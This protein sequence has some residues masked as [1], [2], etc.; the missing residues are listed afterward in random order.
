MLVTVVKKFI[1]SKGGT[2]DSIVCFVI[3][4]HY[5]KSIINAYITLFD[6]S[7]S[8]LSTDAMDFF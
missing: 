8:H 5:M 3:L 1:D 2:K 4:G 7:E 6:C